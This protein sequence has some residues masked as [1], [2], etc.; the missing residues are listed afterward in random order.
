MDKNCRPGAL[1]YAGGIIPFGKGSPTLCVND[2]MG[3]LIQNPEVIAQLQKEDLT[4][5]VKLARE[6]VSLGHYV[7][8]IQ[9]MEPCLDEEKLFVKTVETLVGE[10]GCCISVDCRDPKLVDAALA[11][12]P[13]KAMCN[14][15][16]GEWENLETFLPIIAKH[17]AAVGTACVYEKGVPE[18]VAERL[19]VAR[20]I[21]N[22]AG[23]YG[24]PPEDIMMDCVCLPIGVKPDSLRPTL[25]TIQVI[26]E[27][28]GV[29][30]LLGSSNAGYMLPDM[31]AVNLIYYIATVAVG[32]D[33]AMI[34]PGIPQFNY[35][36]KILKFLMGFDPYGKE[37]F[38]HYRHVRSKMTGHSFAHGSGRE[39]NE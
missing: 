39:G 13:Y 3:Y 21:V 22:E 24:I 16:N 12:Y 36:N 26:H 34:D 5:L 27:E 18:T 9:L 2:Q 33:V 32:L 25:E 17:G 8:N 11:A 20:R 35:F 37:F 10:T 28:L 38:D 30:T 19:Y 6:S 29:A 23:K 31:E 7:V 4:H 1:S 14:V 15:I